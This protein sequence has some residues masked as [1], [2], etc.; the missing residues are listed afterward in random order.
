MKDRADTEIVTLQETRRQLVEKN[1]SGIYSDDIFREQ[2]AIIEDKMTKA[3]IVKEDTLIDNYN[4]DKVTGFL[5]QSSPL[6]WLGTIT[7]D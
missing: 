3:Q 2:N 4:I 5:V 6:E 7:E 1:L